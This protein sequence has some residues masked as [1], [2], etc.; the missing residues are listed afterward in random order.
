MIKKKL[1]GHFNKNELVKLIKNDEKLFDET[2]GLATNREKEDTGWRAAWIINHVIRENDHRII[3][4]A[5]HI[6]EIIKEKEDGHQRELLKIIEKLDYDEKWEGNLLELSIDIWKQVNKSPSLRIVA[7]RIILQLAEKYPEL[8]SE[9]EF[10]SDDRYVETLSPGI[11]Y[12]FLKLR[13]PLTTKKPSN[14]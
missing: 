13:K 3:P 5:P 10:L 12:S 6:V 7:W 1:A 11:R 9:I 4:F 2:L 8:R 14:K